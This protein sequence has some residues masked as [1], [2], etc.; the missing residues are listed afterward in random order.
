M[1]RLIAIAAMA[2][3]LVACGTPGM[4]SALRTNDFPPGSKV[5]AWCT[6]VQRDGD[7]YS[8]AMQRAYAQGWRL[9]YVSEYTSTQRSGIPAELCFERAK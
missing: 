1:Q 7:A 3:A 9:A 6:E 5:E 4:T 8:K 2:V